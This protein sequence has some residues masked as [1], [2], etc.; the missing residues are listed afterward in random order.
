M[1]YCDSQESVPMALSRVLLRSY[2]W[3]MR[4]F[5]KPILLALAAL[6]LFG[7]ANAARA[8]TQPSNAATTAGAQS[9]PGSSTPV[10][11][12]QVRPAF[13]QG[14]LPA[15][16]EQDAASREK[17]EADKARREAQAQEEQ[18]LAQET[19]ARGYWVDPSTGLMWAGKDN[20]VAVT[21]HKAASYCRNLRLAGHSDW[22][23]ATLDE[24]ATLV[25]KSDL[26]PERVGNSDTFT[27]NVGRHVR[28]GLSLT[29]NSWSSTRE[30]DRFGHPYGDGW[31]FDFVNSRPSGDLPYFRNTKYALCVRHSGE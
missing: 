17:A 10:V 1:V 21:W 25:D 24:L 30:I 28:G 11:A 2:S 29:G 22:R 7:A 16:P 15:P 5:G 26:A 13:P 9:S 19:R 3:H 31:F 20:G 8:Q 18:R 27:I 4:N 14:L 12:P 23:L 6:T